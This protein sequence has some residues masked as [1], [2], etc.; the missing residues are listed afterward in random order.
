MK[1]DNSST[2]CRHKTTIDY[3]NYVTRGQ[4]QSTTGNHKHQGLMK[5]FFLPGPRKRMKKTWKYLLPIKNITD[6]NF[7]S[8]HD[9]YLL[10]TPS[11]CLIC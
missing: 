4:E 6:F 1:T 3:K 9:S 7:V 11:L 10:G 5:F 2:L 8:W